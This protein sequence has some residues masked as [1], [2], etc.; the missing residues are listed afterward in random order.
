MRV[1]PFRGVLVAGLLLLAAVGGCQRADEGEW[2]DVSGKVHMPMDPKPGD[3]HVLVFVTN[4]CPIANAYAPSLQGLVEEF[5]NRPVSFFLV[6]VDPDVSAKL[7]LAHA[8][9]YGHKS[10]I[11]LDHEHVLVRSTGVTVTPEVA[12]I[13]PGKEVAY[14]GRIDNWYGDL[15]KKRPKPT[16]H[17]LRDALEAVLAGEEVTVPRTEAVGCYVPDLP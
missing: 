2:T 12:V 1:Y 15:G 11:L 6:H 8:H 16:R 3:V 4:D 10:P 7:A 13:V 17:E 14:R 5:S 9:E